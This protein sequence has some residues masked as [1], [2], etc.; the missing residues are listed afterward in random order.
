MNII[1]INWLKVAIE[2]YFWILNIYFM[3]LTGTK[4]SYIVKS[5]W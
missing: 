4:Y 1:L 2:K 3:S 5:L